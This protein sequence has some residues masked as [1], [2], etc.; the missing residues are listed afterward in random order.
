MPW[1]S[2]YIKTNRIQLHYHRTGGDKPVVV[3][4]HG[5]TDSGLC[6]TRLARTLEADYDL[7]MVDARGHGLSAVPKTGYSTDDHAADLADLV[8]ALDLRRP[9][10]LGHSMGAASVAAF[11]AN[12]PDRAQKLIL[13]DPP[14]RLPDQHSNEERYAQRMAE[15][16]ESLSAQQQLAY[17]EIIAAGRKH[18]PNWHDLEFA[19]WA[20]A[21]LQASLNVFAFR[22]QTEWRA[23]TA[24]IQSPT[25]L[26]TGDPA[27]GAIVNNEATAAL[28][29]SNPM[30]QIATI[31]NAGHNIRRE[32]FELYLQTI[33][34]FLQ[35]S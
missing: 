25:M 24:A 8:Q 13:E 30:I 6:W 5:L 16:R 15:W 34:T 33:R 20:E 17:T 22:P 28:A 3:L 10:L 21:K 23:Q 31:P 29:A 2:G 26:I 12:H 1:A 18:R 19:P 9:I 27:L 4:A 14:W 35:M 32:Q 11:G 7:I